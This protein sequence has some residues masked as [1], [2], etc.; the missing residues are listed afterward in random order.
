MLSTETIGLGKDNACIH[1]GGNSLPFLR[2]LL[3]PK[4]ISGSNHFCSIGARF[5]CLWFIVNF[6]LSQNSNHFLLYDL[7]FSYLAACYF[8][9]LEY[10]TIGAEC[11]KFPTDKTSLRHLS[12]EGIPSWYYIKKEFSALTGQ[13]LPE[14]SI[15]RRTS[16]AQPMEGKSCLILSVSYRY[17]FEEVI[18]Y[19]WTL[20]N[21]V[22]RK[23]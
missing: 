23:C 18:N 14:R 10:E 11:S 2:E 22:F 1:Q 12:R 17:S 7:L 19:F 16:F 15:R 20:S 6:V 13:L 9:V 5:L 3:L 4:M 8:P 21:Y